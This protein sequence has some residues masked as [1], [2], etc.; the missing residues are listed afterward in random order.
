MTRS[1]IIVTHN[2]VKYTKACLKA[3]YEHSGQDWELIVV[4]NASTDGTPDFLV[5]LLGSADNL[6]V[7]LNKTN[8][9]F[10][11]AINQGLAMATGDVIVLLNPDVIVPPCWL[12][13]LAAILESGQ[14]DLVGPI[15]NNVSGAQFDPSITYQNATGFL[16]AVARNREAR[17][18]QL[19]PTVRLV[20]FCLAIH[21]RVVEAI[22]GFDD[23]F[24]PG[25]FEDDDYCIRAH[26]AG[27]DAAIAPGVFVHHE[28]QASFRAS[29][30]GAFPAALMENWGR[31]KDKWNIPVE[32]AYNAG[33][34][35]D[36]AGKEHLLHFPLPEKR[37]V[38]VK[39]VGFKGETP[40]PEWPG[41]SLCI[42][43][44]NEARDIGPCIRSLGDLPTEVIVVDTGSTDDTADIARRLGARVYGFEWC[45]DFAAARNYS[46]GLAT[47]PW[48]LW[49][50][51]DDRWDETNVT[52]LKQALAWGQADVFSC[53]VRSELDD[54]AISTCRHTRL[55]RN[56]IGLEFSGRI[57]ETLDPAIT[58]L[59]VTV[60]V[61]NVE[62]EHLGYQHNNARSARRNRSLLLKELADD[63]ANPK[64]LFYL[65]GNANI[66]GRP[67]ETIR[68]AEMALSDGRAHQL[69]PADLY[70]LHAMTISAHY[71]LNDDEQA[72]A[73]LVSAFDR[74]PTYRHLWLLAAK[75]MLDAAKPQYALWLAEKG[76]TLPPLDTQWPPG[77]AETIKQQAIAQ[78]ELRRQGG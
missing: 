68:Y 78:L 39:Q 59:G 11:G 76:E 57:H 24:Y 30:P 58:R 44:R 45:D 50:D 5:G 20:G 23:R 26:F 22:G 2:A 4:D 35:V 15:S 53:A 41:V 49:T 37:G 12:D 16:E 9:G 77:T 72:Q 3:L 31:F 32:T 74:F 48:V 27:L 34:H 75:V 63:P 73:W 46:I 14:A 54:G 18:G 13:D 66:L 28:G 52:R 56:G 40:P 21:R 43:A 47:Q 70:R 65:A 38:T 62:I 71:E 69:G 36:P 33:Y 25:N 17:R 64:T 7:V 6:R 60:A 19:A 1:V 61:T 8:R 10:A 51:C 29:A 42:I 55:F 67:D